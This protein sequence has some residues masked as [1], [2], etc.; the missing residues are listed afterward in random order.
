MRGML[1]VG[2]I[3]L[4]LHLVLPQIPGIER[5]LRLVAGTSHLQ[6][7][8]AFLAELVSELCYAELLGRSVGVIFAADSSPG[9]QRPRR[10]FML[11]LSP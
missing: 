5:S 1:L 6:V 9:P 11:R 2:S 8:A 3:G 7:G 10:W 4:A